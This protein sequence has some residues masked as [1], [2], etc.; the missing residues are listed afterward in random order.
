MADDPRTRHAAREHGERDDLAD[1]QTETDRVGDTNT[2]GEH[3]DPPG[4]VVTEYAERHAVGGP[5]SAKRF[6]EQ[7]D[8]LERNA[9]SAGDAQGVH[10]PG[11]HARE[12]QAPAGRGPAP[13]RRRSTEQT[14]T[15]DPRSGEPVPEDPEKTRATDVEPRE[16]TSW[17][18]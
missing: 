3:A 8:R 15:I 2:A 12:T 7:A 13:D 14:P 4:Y 5:S 11:R 16:E 6:A 1:G 9:T 18:P 10:G 17:Q